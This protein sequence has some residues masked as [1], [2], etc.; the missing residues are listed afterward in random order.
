MLHLVSIM[1]FGAA[2]AA[3]LITITLTILANAPAMMRALRRESVTT[4]SPPAP[5]IR[6]RTVASRPAAPARAPVRAAA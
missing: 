5:R 3:A 4:W 2:A 6:A 1:F